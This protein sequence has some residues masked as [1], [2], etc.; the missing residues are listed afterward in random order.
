[1]S[2]LSREVD[3]ECKNMFEEYFWETF[4]ISSESVMWLMPLLRTKPE[5]K[6]LFD[7]SVKYK[8]MYAIKNMTNPDDFSL[9]TLFD[10]K[11]LGLYDSDKINY[12]ILAIRDLNFEI[13][14]IL[15]EFF[16][17]KF[18]ARLFETVFMYLDIFLCTQRLF[19]RDIVQIKSK[20]PEECL[21]DR[22]GICYEDFKNQKQ[23]DIIQLGC[24]H[25]F[26][27]KCFTK[28]VEK[29][30]DC[31]PYCRSPLNKEQYKNILFQ[32]LVSKILYLYFGE[33]NLESMGKIIEFLRENGFEYC[34]FW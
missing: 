8:V 18:D 26:C 19:H 29:Y 27:C 30:L 4:V 12:I 33:Q 17:M 9:L 1:M 31:C 24:K 20:I 5:I 13:L 14:D 3:V 25:I 28:G 34:Q 16:E 7:S 22:C 23:F 10:Q 2:Y 6:N 32:K 21:E 15:L 11:D